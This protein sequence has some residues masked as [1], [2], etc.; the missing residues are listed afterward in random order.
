MWARLKGLLF[1]TVMILQ[2]VVDAMLYNESSTMS[3]NASLACEVIKIFSRIAFISSKFGGLSAQGEGSFREYRR[4]FYIALD[5]VLASPPHGERLV[6]TLVM[7]RR[8]LRDGGVN[9]SHPAL[10]AF[11]G[12]LFMTAEQLIDQLSAQCLL[13]EV[14]PVCRE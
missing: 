10:L 4:A 14:L 7:H 2:S 9:G 12:Y 5:I 8:E 6:Q 1:T 3:S 13:E 11:T